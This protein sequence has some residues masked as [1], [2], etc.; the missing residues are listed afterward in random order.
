MCNS[1]YCWLLLHFLFLHRWLALFLSMKAA[2]RLY[3]QRLFDLEEEGQVRTGD[4][5][6]CSERLRPKGLSRKDLILWLNR[7]TAFPNVRTSPVLQVRSIHPHYDLYIPNWDPLEKPSVV[8]IA[9]RGKDETL[10][11]RH[12]SLA[13]PKFSPEHQLV[14][15]HTKCS[16]PQASSPSSGI[17]RGI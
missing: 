17:Q 9:A 7:P 1:F 5:E 2:Y 4:G 13:V 6:G 12:V 15:G 11:E 14:F 10:L 8:H 3:Y 16:L